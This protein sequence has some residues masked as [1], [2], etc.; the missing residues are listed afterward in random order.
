MNIYLQ[1]LLA[2]A[3]LYQTYEGSPYGDDTQVYTNY[4]TL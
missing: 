3:C 4:Y 2:G 1:V